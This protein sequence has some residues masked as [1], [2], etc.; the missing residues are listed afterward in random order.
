MRKHITFFLVIGW[1]V[2]SIGYSPSFIF[3]QEKPEGEELSMYTFG[4]VKQVSPTMIIITEYDYATDK[5]VDIEYTIDNSTQFINASSIADIQAGDEIE[6]VFLEV[7]GKKMA[8][9]I[10]LDEEMAEQR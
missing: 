6:I 7:D 10:S 2:G 9:S 4:V 1:L 8:R 5:E 3:A